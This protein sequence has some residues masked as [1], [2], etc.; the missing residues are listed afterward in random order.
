MAVYNLQAL[1]D[2]TKYFMTVKGMTQEEA[3]AKVFS[4]AGLSGTDALSQSVLD[5]YHALLANPTIDSRFARNDRGRILDRRKAMEEP[6][7]DAPPPEPPSE[8]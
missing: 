6:T 7:Q 2:R 3:E 1:A 8:F 5:Q 4:E